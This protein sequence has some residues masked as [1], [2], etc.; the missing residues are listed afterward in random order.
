MHGNLCWTVDFLFL[1]RSVSFAF[2]LPSSKACIA[3]DRA[4]ELFCGLRS[5]LNRWSVDLL[6]LVPSSG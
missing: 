1:V 3:C 4:Q 2:S 5:S 6:A